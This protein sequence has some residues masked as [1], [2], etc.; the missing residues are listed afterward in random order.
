MSQTGIDTVRI[1]LRL[2]LLLIDADQFFATP[3]VF[4]KAIVRDSIK[5]CG[6][7]RFTAKAADVFVG[8]EKCFLR[9]VICQSNVCAGELAQK[10]AHTRLMPA[11]EFAEGMLIV[12]GKNSRNK[13]CIG[14][15]HDRNIRVRE[16]EAE[17]PFCFP[18]SI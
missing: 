9:K 16:A 15:L 10:T 5:P 3:R 7:S 12:I 18:I 1:L 2:P 13:I 6:K 8:P 14:E 17:C 11:H 4:A